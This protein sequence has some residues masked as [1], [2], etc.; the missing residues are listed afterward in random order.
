MKRLEQ[1]KAELKEAKPKVKRLTELEE[2]SKSE[3]EKAADRI[4]K[5]EAEAASVPAKVADALRTHLAALHDFDKD[6]VELFLTA[7]DP[8]V[9]LKQVARLLSPVGGT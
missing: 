9:L 6:D 2:A 7:D 1:L 4:A 5:A 3:A 8:E